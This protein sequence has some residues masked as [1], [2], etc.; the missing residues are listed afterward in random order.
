MLDQ[1]DLQAQPGDD[2]SLQALLGFDSSLSLEDPGGDYKPVVYEGVAAQ[3]GSPLSIKGEAGLTAYATPTSAEKQQRCDMASRLLWP[4]LTHAA[5]S[6]APT[7]EQTP[8]SS[9]A[10]TQFARDMF[11]RRICATVDATTSPAKTRRLLRLS[12]LTL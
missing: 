7:N 5:L 10:D 2:G 4:A 11:M 3:Y 8:C 9:L 1:L 12:S 6:P